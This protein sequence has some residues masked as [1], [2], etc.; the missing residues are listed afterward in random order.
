MIAVVFAPD[1]PLIQAFHLDLL[2]AACIASAADFVI[3]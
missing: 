3:R 1:C 2:I